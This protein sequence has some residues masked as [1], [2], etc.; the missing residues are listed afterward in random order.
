[1]LSLHLR[2]EAG[3]YNFEG[4]VGLDNCSGSIVRF[5]NS[6]DNDP[7]MVLTNGHCYE[8]GFTDPGH[9]VSGVQSSRRFSVLDPTAGTLG[10]V[11]ANLVIYSTM[12]GTDMTLYR[13]N[14]TYTDI[15][16]KY[17]VHALTLSSSHPHATDK[18]E[19]ISGYWKKGYQCSID[20][21][22]H[23]L[24]EDQWTWTDSIRYSRPGCE[25]IGGT[26][27]SPILLAGT[28]TVIGVN[29]TGNDDGEKCT[30]DNPCE[31]DENGNITYQQGL[32]YGQQTYWLYTCLNANNEVDLSTAGCLLPH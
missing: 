16:S 12:T 15:L 10:K 8:G 20:N 28:R 19:I 14:E 23:Q 31:I 32:S 11:T 25:T 13:L 24:H 17:G 9:F 7:A 21:F 5:E 3:D 1:M 26:S 2:T 22:V 6:R 29:N 27:G 18:V 4:I 30:M